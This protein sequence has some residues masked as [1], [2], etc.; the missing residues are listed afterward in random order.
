MTY[1]P[2]VAGIEHMKVQSQ[3]GPEL[4]KGDCLGSLS[5]FMLGHPSG[6]DTALLGWLHSTHQH[7]YHGGDLATFLRSVPRAFPLWFNGG[8]PTERHPEGDGHVVCAAIPFLCWS[9]DRLRDGFY[10]R[11][12][13][14]SILTWNSTHPHRLLG[15]TEDIA[16]FMLPYKPHSKDARV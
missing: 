6:Q 9:E 4:P 14:D 11:V 7:P 1:Y 16:G 15:W 5:N 2:K 13:I 10:D 8:T 3:H 12:R